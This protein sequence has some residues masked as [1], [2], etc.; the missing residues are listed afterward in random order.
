MPKHNACSDIKKCI[1]DRLNGVMQNPRLTDRFITHLTDNYIISQKN[2]TNL[3]FGKYAF[4][5]LLTRDNKEVIN[6]RTFK[7]SYNNIRAFLNGH[8]TPPPKTDDKTMY[9]VVRMTKIGGSGKL[10]KYDTGFFAKGIHESI[11]N[12]KFYMNHSVFNASSDIHA[13]ESHP[14]DKKMYAKC[15]FDVGQDVINRRIYLDHIAWDKVTSGMNDEDRS[16]LSGMESTTAVIEFL[17]VE[18]K[19]DIESA[20]QPVFADRLIEDSVYERYVDTKFIRYAFDFDSPFMI[21]SDDVNNYGLKK[22]C[23]FKAIMN[24][25]KSSF[26]K[27]HRTLRSSRDSGL[28]L[29]A[30]LVCQVCMQKQYKRGDEL[31][32]RVFEM[33]RFFEMFKLGL[34]IFDPLGNKLLEQVPSTFHSKIRPRVLD[35]I[36]NNNHVTSIVDIK[37]FEQ[38][39]VASLQYELSSHYIFKK[40]DLDSATTYIMAS[41]FDQVIEQTKSMNPMPAKIHVVWKGPGLN[42]LL[43]HLVLNG[44][45]PSVQVNSGMS[46]TSISFKNLYH[47]DKNVQIYIGIMAVSQGDEEVV[48]GMESIEVYKKYKKLENILFE[49]LVHPTKKSELSKATRDLFAEYAVTIPIGSTEDFADGLDVTPSVIDMCKHYASCLANAD[50]L[51]SISPFEKFHL[52]KQGTE[53]QRDMLYIVDILPGCKNPIY[54]L[55]DRTLMFY[56]ELID[57]VDGSDVSVYASI[58]V[59]LHPNITLPILIRDIFDNGGEYDD[60]PL[61]LRKGLVNRAIGELGRKKNRTRS[62]TV[63]K[64]L[65]DAI[66][67][68]QREGSGIICTL[69]NNL[70]IV[71]ILREKELEDGFVPINEM[72]KSMARHQMSNLWKQLT[73][74]GCR[75]IGFKTDAMYFIEPD[76]PVDIVSH[77]DELSS[78]SGSGNPIGKAKYFKDVDYS[79]PRVRYTTRVTNKA[80]ADIGYRVES[81]TK[82]C[83]IRN[84]SEHLV[85]GSIVIAGAGCGKTFTLL[86]HLKA[87]VDPCRILVVTAW[88][89]QANR[90]KQAFHLQ[91]IT[92][93]HLRGAKLDDT[94]RCGTRGYDTSGIDVIVFDEIMLFDH[95]KLVKLS[96]YMQS[97]PRIQYYATGDPIQLEAIGDII[98]NAYKLRILSNTLLFPCVLGLGTN[99]RIVQK[100][101]DRLTSIIHDVGSMSISDLIDKHFSRNKRTLDEFRRSGLKR[102]IAYYNSSTRLLNKL[103]HPQ[104]PHSKHKLSKTKEIH[105]MRYYFGDTLVCKQQVRVGNQEKLHVNYQYTIEAMNDAIFRLKDIHTMVVSDVCTSLI[106]THFSFPYCSTVHSSQGGTIDVPFI[107]ADAYS[108]HVT[109]NW[110]ISALTR[111]SRLDDVYFLTTELKTPNNDKSLHEMVHHYKYQDKMKGFVVKKDTI[112]TTAW[113][114]N[115]YNDA[116]GMCKY[117]GEDMVFEK[118]NIRKVTV[119][120]L[121]NN[122]GHVFGNIEVCCW[123]CNNI[124]R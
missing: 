83:D 87:S 108:D 49:L 3:E 85:P 76:H 96:R 57:L 50:N 80:V 12:K 60:I 33:V 7:E 70:W 94:V 120:R 16:F 74:L 119:N 91:A 45:T 100:D 5:H 78:G 82:Q 68:K 99:L 88:N 71:K 30:D 104:V 29:T 23:A 115:A 106:P 56:D 124:L 47:C 67:H 32:M 95:A 8:Y 4:E 122:I 22:S 46:V 66:I 90:I 10:Y 52:H 93:H 123:K 9:C 81:E 17:K 11:V 37:S 89:A 15:F 111:C 35:L 55:K 39:H 26:D 105:G 109:K 97:N 40:R 38:S 34:R 27:Y 114:R 64:N 73:S 86:H 72:I 13:T 69:S 21:K 20:E 2:R 79:Y 107:V 6:V 14:E 98:D 75:V 92:W 112:V 58:R 103:I 63:Y 48:D 65:D 101:R 77:I 1:E 24:A 61:E 31:N 42:D 41:S 18:Y 53:L 121:N 43:I 113:I 118:N 51:V 44:Y 110:I 116:K 59:I 28:E 19:A 25:Y 36:Y 84:I 102:G 62:A 117:C 54:K